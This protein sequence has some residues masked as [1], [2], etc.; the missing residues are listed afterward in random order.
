MLIYQTNQQFPEENNINDTN[1]QSNKIKNLIIKSNNILYCP[2]N[3]SHYNY[4]IISQNINNLYD[5]IKNKLLSNYD[6]LIN[7]T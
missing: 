1:F 2:I 4:D 5:L 7:N 6:K 3:N